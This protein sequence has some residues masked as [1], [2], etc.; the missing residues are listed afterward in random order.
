MEM[1]YSCLSGIKQILLL[2]HFL[3]FDHVF[4]LLLAMESLSY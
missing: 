1:K 2:P 3:T 4:I